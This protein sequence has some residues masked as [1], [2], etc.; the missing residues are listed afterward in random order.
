V[1]AAGAAFGVACALLL[2][3][4]GTTA[5]D[6]SPS[7][8]GSVAPT[9]PVDASVA[10]SGPVQTA[11]AYGTG[12]EMIAIQSDNV[13]AAGYD[14]ATATMTVEFDSGEV[15]EYAPVPVSVWQDFLSAQPHPWSAVGKPQLVD[16][17]IP[18]RKV[19]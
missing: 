7:T 6:T 11:P 18:Y 9:G 19:S 4:C 15:Y 10:A 3:G 17:G 2:G 8:A 14:A 13:N 12:G 1:T 16:A 5:G